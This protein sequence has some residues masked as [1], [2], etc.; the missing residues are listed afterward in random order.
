M[1]F[2][3]F[4]IKAQEAVQKAVN[5]AQR[6][7]Q[8]SIEP[9]H[10]LK[11]LMNKAKDVTNFLFQKLGVNAMQIETVVDREISRL[12]RVQGGQP[13][14]SNESNS[15]LQKA[16]D[17]SQKMGDEFISVEP[18]MLALLEVNSTASRIMK[19]A[20]CTEK[21][22]R[23]AINELRQGQKVQSQSADEN[24]QSLENMPRTWLRRH[25]RA[26]STL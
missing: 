13:Y 17:I 19:D 1:T 2:D 24:Y 16:V 11:G 8:Q 5:T 25:V 14:L 4:T 10:L 21:E 23:A 12:P 9:V 20:G 3:K 22:M 15:V 18:V 6:S 7:G 26:N